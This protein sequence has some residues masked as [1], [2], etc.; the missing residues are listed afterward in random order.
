MCDHGCS[1]FKLKKFLNVPLSI[2]HA[3]SLME[4]HLKLQLHIFNWTHGSLSIFLKIEWCRFTHYALTAVPPIARNIRAWAH[5]ECINTL[6]CTKIC[7][8]R[9]KNIYS[10]LFVEAKFKCI[11]IKSNNMYIVR[12]ALRG[13]VLWAL[14]PLGSGNS[15]GFRS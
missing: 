11:F 7:F 3:V 5:K 13:G 15:M 10:T 8:F 1:F 12:V 4:S 2:G 6:A 9:S 14:S